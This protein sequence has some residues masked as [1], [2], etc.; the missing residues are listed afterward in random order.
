MQEVTPITFV[1]IPA[2]FKPYVVPHGNSKT[3]KPTWPST[4]EFIKKEGCASEVVA[5]VSGK[6]GGVM[7]ASA[8]GQ[9]PRGGVQCQ[10]A[11]AIQG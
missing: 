10:V 8:P 11:F 9:L 3:C 1:Y 4:M 6:V 2:G 5:L 7:G